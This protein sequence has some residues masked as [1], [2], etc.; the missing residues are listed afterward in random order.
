MM[1]F[2]DAQLRR[3]DI[4]LL[5]VFDEAMAS[6]KLSAAAKRLGLTQS[7]ISHAIK[8]LRDIFDD[9]LFIRTPRGV[10]PTPRAM[11]LRAP[12]TDALRLIRGAVSPAAFDP[13][14]DERVFRIAATDYETSLFAPLLLDLDPASVTPRYI[15][16]ALIRREAIEAVQAG[17]I[18]LLL[19]YAS[20]RRGGCDS[21]TLFEED[22]LVVARQGHPALGTALTLERYAAFGHVLMSPGGSLT[23]VVDKALADACLSRRVVVA[24][25]YFFAVLATVARTDMIATLPRRLAAGH[26]K[27]FG[28]STMLPPMPIRFFPVRMVW[29]R[30]LGVDP[31]IVWLRAKV[32]AV[33]RLLEPQQGRAQGP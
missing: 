15:F 10:Q 4:T 12:L 30:R 21:E 9:E 32:A 18:D 6:G 5:L 24:V 28:L 14:R 13:A 1:N 29:S 11:A 26:A 19:G 20:D 23:G 2:N 7:A 22:Y 8:R 31:A 3:L 16:R 33:A 17:D 25:P 27:D